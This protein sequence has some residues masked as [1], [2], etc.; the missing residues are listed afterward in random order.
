MD[1]K[2]PEWLPEILSDV[3]ER[4]DRLREPVEAGDG[5][6]IMMGVEQCARYGLAMPDWLASAFIERA[7]LV[8]KPPYRKSW[9][10][11]FGKPWPGMQLK[12]LREWMGMRLPVHLAVQRLQ[13]EN[14]ELAIDEIFQRV[15]K[16]LKGVGGASSVRDLYYESTEPFKKASAKRSRKLPQPSGKTKART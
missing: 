14:P 6:A 16:D 5:L 10:D 2:P 9:D 11:A 15:A 13:R 3:Q 4:L 12:H 8:L 1:K 7:L